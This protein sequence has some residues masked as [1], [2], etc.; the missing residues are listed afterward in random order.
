MRKS[1]YKAKINRQ[2]DELKAESR[3]RG[4]N[5]IMALIARGIK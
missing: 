1:A 2:R 4:H 5:K 3:N